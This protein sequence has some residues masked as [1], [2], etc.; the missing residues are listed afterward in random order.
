MNSNQFTKELGFIA[1]DDIRKFTETA[2]DNLPQYFF[3]CAASSTGKYHPCYAL[4]DGGLVRHTKAAVRFANHLF[5]LEQIQNQFSQREMDCIISAL[6]LHDGW[7]HGNGNSSFTVHEHPQVC[8]DWVKENEI[9]FELL[10]DEDRAM[11]AEGIASH[12]GQWNENK[13]SKIVLKKPQTDIQKF[14][15]ICDYLASRK[16]IEII[17]DDVE[18]PKADINTYTLPFGKHKGELFLDVVK[19]DKSYLQWANENMRLQEPLKTFIAEA[20]K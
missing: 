17:F 12:M 5:Q 19:N 14:V 9:F 10:P 13:R 7:K 1:N 2:L 20:L 8:A 16:D 18:T 3:E 11:I 4:G 6:I 15:H